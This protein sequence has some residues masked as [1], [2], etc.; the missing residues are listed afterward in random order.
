[1]P[2]ASLSGYLTA[3]SLDYAFPRRFQRRFPLCFSTAAFPRQSCRIALLPD[4]FNG[5]RLADRGQSDGGCGTAYGLRR[6]R[7][8]QICTTCSFLSACKSLDVRLAGYDVPGCSRWPSM[9][10]VFCL[11]PQV[12]ALIIRSHGDVLY[13]VVMGCNNHR[14]KGIGS[15]VAT[16]YS[17][18][19][20]ACSI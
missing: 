1:M 13:A 17:S 19:Q 10:S 6:P 2:E 18:P 20:P 5:L 12:L 3:A 16:V 9:L 11:S 4:P 7:A 15:R 8:V 14:K